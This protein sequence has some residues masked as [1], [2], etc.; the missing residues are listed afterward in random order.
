[1][2]VAVRV[3]GIR[4]LPVGVVLALGVGL[5]VVPTG[6]ASAA[7]VSP[8]AVTSTA[9]RHFGDG[10]PGVGA[11]VDATAVTQMPDGD[12]VFFDQTARALR[13]VDSATG[14]VDVL[15][16][17]PAVASNGCE[18]STTGSGSGTSLA[19]VAQLWSDA[20]GDV[21]AWRGYSWSCF[22]WGD[23]YRLDHT[24][25]SW[26]VAVAQPATPCCGFNGNYQ[27][28][29]VD[30]AGDIFAWDG[31]RY[32][33]RKFAAGTDPATG[34]QVVAGVLDS[35]SGTIATGG[36]AT[37]TPIG[38][39]E[40]M[41]AAPDGSLYLSNS[42]AHRIYRVDA[43]TGVLSSV[44]GTGAATPYGQP[45]ADD[46]LDAAAA[47]IDVDRLALSADGA[48]LYFSD[49]SGQITSDRAFSVGGP[50]RTVV[51]P[52]NATAGDRML[53]PGPV[54]VEDSQTVPHRLIVAAAGDLRAWPSDGSTATSS[55]TLVAGLQRWPSVRESADGTTL[56]RAFLGTVT[57]VAQA[58]DGHLA[59]AT[60]DSVRSLSGLTPTATLGTVSHEGAGA[61]AFDGDGTLLASSASWSVGNPRVVRA[62]A[63][64][65]TTRVVL[66]GGSAA[67]AEGV[68]GTDVD[69]SGGGLMA[70]DQGR[71]VLYVRPVAG[72]VWAL[73]L[74]TGVLHLFA[75]AAGSPPHQW[76]DG[77][78]AI[79]SPVDGNG[80]AVDQA[81]HDVYV[82]GPAR[83]AAD[84]TIHR[85]GAAD[86]GS[87]STMLFIPGGPL[88]AGTQTVGADGATASPLTGINPIAV[89]ADGR[90]VG[91]G[92]TPSGGLLT[93]SD[94]VPA[95][96]YGDPTPTIEATAGP[97][98]AT[99][100]VT[101]PATSGR[102]VTVTGAAANPPSGA[103]PLAGS[104]LASFVTDGTTTPHTFTFYR[105]DPACSPG[106]GLTAGVPYRFGVT[107]SDHQQSG[108]AA[109]SA[110]A[111]AT[112]TPTADTQ[113]PAAPTASLS[114]G[115]GMVTPTVTVPS[116]PDTAEL[117]VRYSTTGTAPASI[118]DGQ[119][120]ARYTVGQNPAPGATVHFS[121]MFLDP[122]TPYSISAFATDTSGNVSAAGTAVSPAAG[123][124]AGNAV[125]GVGYVG[126]STSTD[127]YG[128]LAVVRYAPGTTPPATPASGTDVGSLSTQW[129]AMAT[130]PVA[131]GAKVAVSVF[132]WNDDQTAY[133]RSSF[134][135][136]GGQSSDTLTA[137]AP[138]VVTGGAVPTV[139][140][141]YL[142]HSP[143]VVSPRSGQT[144]SL[145][146]RPVGTASWLLVG[147]A[148]TDAKGAVAFH[149]P[150]PTGA[151]DYQVRAVGLASTALSATRRTYVQPTLT[152]ALST[153]RVRHGTAL[154][155]SGTFT[156]HKVAA[157]RLQRYLSGSW[158]TVAYVNSAS[159][160]RYSFRY[161]P[162]TAGTYVLRVLAPAT[163]TVRQAISPNRS[164]SVL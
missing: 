108:L 153:T 77:D 113:A 141:S 130:V 46:G 35:S 33:V 58:P 34:G 81:T 82:T 89:L 59:I 132:R 1:M 114:R 8:L 97:A 17:T 100:T 154:Y 99:V 123:L 125:T 14:T 87:P 16:A 126:H 50:I 39:V 116:D 119:Q 9:S 66:G 79:G 68:Q 102:V 139:T 42:T 93:I 146:R 121:S 92:G 30:A 27:R 158:R 115:Y 122:M 137:V 151:V 162:A 131:T 70:V 159:T 3:S 63:S 160:G 85:F 37:A 28:F 73:D 117:E 11:W 21:F 112:V 29:T 15:A 25:L 69:F 106:S 86:P 95:P 5:A 129:G 150:T 67:F 56:D 136:T 103:C 32:V 78:P 10:G 54:M 143:D 40:T 128:S 124:I 45:S 41:A 140:A 94:P 98:Q 91:R 74:G 51:G 60:P 47:R 64:D 104:T 152:A 147:S 18:L 127:I 83:I 145:Y 105:V 144:V 161:V 44:A 101:P 80:L 31:K 148:T 52:A 36:A 6:V 90:L 61:V 76:A 24:D 157:L 118:T 142:R 134:V 4:L 75:G 23:L 49:T 133:Q 22:S 107:I 135:L 96:V 57:A 110:P 156:P 19:Q 12:V 20:A 149:P 55:G 13:R 155:V 72:S 38:S 109:S 2:V 111:F 84:G 65:G 48:T 7:A 164:L 120:L 138:A 26:H 53:S 62:S 163:T 88:L 71:H 43:G